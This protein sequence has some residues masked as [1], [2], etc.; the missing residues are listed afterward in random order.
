MLKIH[1]CFLH[2]RIHVFN[3]LWKILAFIS[4]NRFFFLQC[5]N[6][7]L[8]V[9]LVWLHFSWQVYLIIFFITNSFCFLIKRICSFYYLCFFFIFSIQQFSCSLW[10]ISLCVFIL[11]A[12][13]YSADFF[14]GIFSWPGMRVRASSEEIYFSYRRCTAP[15][16]MLAYF[17]LSFRFIAFVF[18]CA[19][20]FCLLS[21][22]SKLNT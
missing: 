17:V 6:S 14:C 4:L 19:F 12:N 7:L 15:Y 16:F 2:T 13:L 10:L 1:L 18:C 11:I 22:R 20:I 21:D 9:L 5:L 3:Q 8:K